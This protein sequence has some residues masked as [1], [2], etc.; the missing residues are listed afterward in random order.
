MSK[1]ELKKEK[2]RLEK[3]L[4]MM[5]NTHAKQFAGHVNEGA[6]EESCQ[7][8]RN[9]YQQLECICNTLGNPIPVRF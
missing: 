1:E 3:K 4:A 8:I 7:Q 5:Q 9:V 2:D 6:Y